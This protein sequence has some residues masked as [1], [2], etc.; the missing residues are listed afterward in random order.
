MQHFNLVDL[1]MKRI[2]NKA[3]EDGYTIGILKHKPVIMLESEQEPEKKLEEIEEF[4]IPDIQKPIARKQMIVDSRKNRQVDRDMIIDRINRKKMT[5]MPMVVGEKYREEEKD[6]EEK[7]EEKKKKTEEEQ[8]QKEEQKEEQEK[9]QEKEQ[10]EEEKEEYDELD[11]DALFSIAA[12]NKPIPQPV[13]LIKTVG[14]KKR[15]IIEP[16][17]VEE[18]KAEK[19]PVVPRKRKIVRIDVEPT[20]LNVMAAKIGEHKIVDRLPK[21]KEKIIVK[22]SQYYMNNRKIYIQKLNDLFKPYRKELSEK[23]ESISCKKQSKDPKFELLTH[24]KIVRDYLNIYTPYRGLLLFHGLGSG[25]TCTSIA[26]AEG[27]KSH[28]R[29]FV[30][31]PASL[32]MNF[33]SE[34]KKCGDDLYKKNQFWE[35]VS[36]EG[37][38]DYIGTLAKAM[39]L[40]MEYV[41]TNKGAWLVDVSKKANFTDL[42]AT[43]QSE[44]DEQLNIMIRAKYTD[45]NYNGMTM[46]KLGL[47]TGDFSRNPFDNSVIIVDEAH[48]FVSRIVNKLPKSEGS[49]T[50]KDQAGKKTISYMLYDY[51]LSATNARVVLLTGTPIINYPNEIGILFNILRGY[52]KTW[53]FPVRV[54]SKEAVNR[55]SILD[56]FDKENFK[57]YDYVE[58]SGNNLTITRNPFGFINTKKRSAP[59]SGVKSGVK[60]GGESGGE[61]KSKG[62]TK[63]NKSTARKSKSVT[64]KHRPT[65]KDAPLYELKDGVIKIRTK[66]YVDDDASQDEM[67]SEFHNDTYTGDF[68]P[69]QGGDGSEIFDQYNGV[70]LDETGNVS[71]E[72]FVAMIKRI[73]GK[74]GIDVIEGKIQVVNNK[75]LPDESDTFMNMFIEPGAKE[76]KNEN[77]FKRRILGLSSY[78]RSAQEKLLP[79]Y[80]R[81]EEGGI[82]HIVR[83]EMSNYQFGIYEKIRKDEEARE[84][85]N[86]KKK[87]QQAKKGDDLFTVASTYRIFSRSA[88]N[89]AFPDPPG[90]PMP[91]K[92]VDEINENDYNATPLS[93]RTE[94]DD[95]ITEEDVDETKEAEG[96]P[97][98]DYQKRIETALKYLEYDPKVDRETEFLTPEGLE[99]YSPKF[100]SILDNLQDA[101]NRGLHLI[102][103]QFRTIE[104][105]GILKL[106]LEA[107]GFAEFKLKK[108]GND[109]WDIVE[110][111]GNEGKPRFVLYTGTETPEEK[112]LIR[113]IYNSDW[114]YVPSD[115]VNKLKE[116]AENNMYGDI[117]KILMITASG[118]EGINLKNTRFVHIVEPY[119]HMVRLEQVIGRARRICSHEDLPEELRNIKVFLY[120]SVLSKQQKTDEKHIELHI[121]DVSKLDG[122]TPITTDESLF[123]TATL[124]DGINQQILTAIKETAIDCSL[125]AAGNKSEELVCYGFGKVESNQFSS[126]PTLQQDQ[127]TKG[128]IG[129]KVKTVKFGNVTINKIKYAFDERTNEL[130]DYDSTQRAKKNIN[131]EIIY[132]GRLVKEGP[133]KYR[134]DENAPRA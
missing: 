125:Y 55:D 74:N 11:E 24:Q 115:L 21:N 27:M 61:S 41:Q 17:I 79:Q 124:K 121:R 9:E 50:K 44:I 36:T 104:G 13:Q 46:A 66:P 127:A 12:I 129:E 77:I 59:K 60:N 22:A 18:V 52:I 16:T 119:W 56:M 10:E 78:F 99:T 97:S 91:N 51:L 2:P 132:I 85:S 134:I 89:F 58:Y 76:M 130:F 93:Q 20:M 4:D 32:K 15:F 87:L 64:K 112:E 75:A 94:S 29:V 45:I 65:D 43:Q 5:K 35:F 88:C 107:N 49:N 71:D 95:Y 84:K 118:A 102:Y 100:L 37:K 67:M 105:V 39:Q 109:S 96:E 54:T 82:F 47:L 86:R 7:K 1:Q 113:N 62:F 53:T 28:K 116:T 14:P 123:E 31:T 81:N 30:M 117:I 33:F 92:A 80:V 72:M 68:E 63:R 128:E 122:K 120:L 133:K 101:D 108:N 38:P 40:P 69:H 73:L 111:E 19:P 57:T 103:S 90:R 3:K 126:Y 131:E 98:A 106:I 26:I 42:D 34:L 6:E 23:E 8:E 48:N 83:S 25:K 70:H 110:K 114:E